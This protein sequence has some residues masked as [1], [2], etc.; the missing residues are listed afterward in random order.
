MVAYLQHSLLRC[1]HGERERKEQTRG[2]MIAATRTG[3]RL[4]RAGGKAVVCH[5]DLQRLR[6]GLQHLQLIDIRAV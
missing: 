3:S 5:G 2:N 1:F 6:D 4:G